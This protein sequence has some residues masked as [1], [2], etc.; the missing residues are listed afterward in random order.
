MFESD[1]Q[2]SYS[3]LELLERR[4]FNAKNTAVDVCKV[5]KLCV[6]IKH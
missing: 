1:S 6:N 3:L 2:Q 4:I 5:N